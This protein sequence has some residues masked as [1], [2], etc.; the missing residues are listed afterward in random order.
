MQGYDAIAKY[1]YATFLCVE[2]WCSEWV[3][4]KFTVAS[5]EGAG[6]YAGSEESVGRE[7]SQVLSVVALSKNC[8]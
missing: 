6:R 2:F 5:G 8:Q 1:M 4:S 7:P 3:N